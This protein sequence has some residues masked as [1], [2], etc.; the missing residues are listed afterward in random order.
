MAET[1]KN[2]HKIWRMMRDPWV[3]LAVMGTMV[4]MIIAVLAVRL[5]LSRRRTQAEQAA[6][7]F[8][9]RDQQGRLTSLAQYRGKVVAL[10]FIDPECHQLCPLT[11]QSMVEALKMLGP[12]AASHVQLLGID[13]NPQKTQVAD[14][15]DYT[16]T[17]ALEGRWRFL[18][19]SLPQLKSIWRSYG[20]Y[21]AVV[22]NDI[23]HTAVIFLIDRNGYE[24]GTYS[25]PMSYEAVGDQAQTLA[26]GI[27]QLLPGHPAV[28]APSET[29]QQDYSINPARTVDLIALGPNHQPVVLGAVHPHLV[30][31]FAAWLGQDSDL[32]KNLAVLDSYAALARLSFT[33]L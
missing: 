17:H 20:V 28:S 8:V 15:D 2:S 21:V 24:R 18:T 30:L 31:F 22:N 19:G 29:S 13:A 16:R 25:T 6:P 10:T 27:A 11:T 32:S 1:E 9:L 14:L 33:C 3:L 4:A 26:A 23:E 12:A 7:G 5:L